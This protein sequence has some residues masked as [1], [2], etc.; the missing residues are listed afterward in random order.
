MFLRPLA[1]PKERYVPRAAWCRPGV[2]RVPGG[3]SF[4]VNSDERARG[5]P[6][7]G[8]VCRS[9]AAP[10]VWLAWN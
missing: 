9:R 4:G 7:E 2:D 1:P 8:P 5:P 6:G 3:I 10:E